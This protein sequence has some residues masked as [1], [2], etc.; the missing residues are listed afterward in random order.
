MRELST[1]QCLMPSAWWAVSASPMPDAAATVG[2]L[3]VRGAEVARAGS[4]LSEKEVAAIYRGYGDLMLRRC[5]VVLRDDALADDAFQDAFVNLIKYGAAFREAKSPLRWLYTLCDR[6][7]FQQLRKRRSQQERVA[8]AAREPKPT[9]TH[10]S[11]RL[12]HRDAVLKLLATLGDKERQVAVLAYVDGLSQ[13]EIGQELG[14]SRQTINKKL[15]Q[16][17]EM[18]VA[19]LRSREARDATESD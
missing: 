2:G 18:A 10:I 15:R 1:V 8:E 13:A 17:R 5:R 3:M 16:I 11:A 4:R 12:E 7:C 19:L 9:A 14:W 6:A